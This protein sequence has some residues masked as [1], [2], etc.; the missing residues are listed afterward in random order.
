[1]DLKYSVNRVLTEY[2]EIIYN[3][4]VSVNT[5]LGESKGVTVLVLHVVSVVI[6]SITWSLKY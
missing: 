6:A 3:Y 1:M 5:H 4:S 2:T